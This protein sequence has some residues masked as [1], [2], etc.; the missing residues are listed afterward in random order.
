MALDQSYLDAIKNF[1]GYTP[2]ASWDYKQ[3]SSGYGTKAQ[4]GDENIPADQLKGVYE[5]RFQDEV[6]KAASSVD[7]F[8]PNL[9]PGVRAALTSLTYNAGPGWQQSGLGQAVK[10]G[11]YDAAKNIFLQYNKAGGEVNDGLVARR[12]KEAAWFGG[13][14]QAAQP[15][16]QPQPAPASPAAPANGLLAQGTG[17]TSTPTSGGLL[18]G[19]SGGL[20]API[21]P[22]Q[23][24]QQAAPADPPYFA[25]IPAEQAMQAPPIQFAQRR[26][27]NLTALRNSLQ[28]RAP[29]FAKG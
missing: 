14:P 23:A 10:S 3:Y 5:Q 25:Q 8:A 16:G 26:P 2:N 20:M 7:A 24:P 15:H 27:V 12:Q 19:T 13:Q 11:D 4:A 9:P 28:Q 1:E 6:G 17:G 21:F 22:Q 29:F 18:P